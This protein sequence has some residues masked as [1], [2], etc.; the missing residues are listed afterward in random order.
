MSRKFVISSFNSAQHE[1][2]SFPLNLTDHTTLVFEHKHKDPRYTA[3][4]TKLK[5]SV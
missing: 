4:K 3:R 5:F 2:G 1:K